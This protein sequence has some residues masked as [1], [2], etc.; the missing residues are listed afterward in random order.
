MSQNHHESW[1]KT[2]SKKGGTLSAK[3]YSL[4]RGKNDS[5]VQVEVFYN[6][7][8]YQIILSYLDFVLIYL[9]CNSKFHF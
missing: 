7:K 8:G 3:Y 5:S 4:E 6:G 9:F 1:I 2:S